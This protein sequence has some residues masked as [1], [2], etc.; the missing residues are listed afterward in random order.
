M[1]LGRLE[2]CALYCHTLSSEGSKLTKA[3]QQQ[4]LVHPAGAPS[5]AQ[6]PH[7][8]HGRSPCAHDAPLGNR[9][10]SL[11]RVCSRAEFQHPDPDPAAML[12]LFVLG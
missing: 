3:S 4:T 12:L 10:R 1:Y 9:R 7:K 8:K 11:R 5:M 6:L 2:Q